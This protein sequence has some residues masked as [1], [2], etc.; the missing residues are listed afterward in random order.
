MERSASL[1]S[2]P[3]SSVTPN[4]LTGPSQLITQR[5]S[6]HA[7]PLS[8]VVTSSPASCAS[9]SAPVA[10]AHRWSPPVVVGGAGRF[11]PVA[12]AHR[13]SPSCRGGA[14]AGAV[15][16]P[17]GRCSSRVSLL[18]WWVVGGAGVICPSGRCSSLVSLLS[19]WCVGGCGHLPQW[20]VLI[21]GLPPVGGGW[22]V[23]LGGHLPQWPVLIAG[24]P[25]VAVVR[26]R[27]RSL[28]P[29]AGAHRGSPPVVMG[30]GRSLAWWPVL[31]GN[32]PSSG[33]AWAAGSACTRSHGDVS[34]RA[35][36]VPIE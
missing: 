18:G 13:W 2:L 5:S 12:G 14:W 36:N 23:V 19:W 26:R 35:G 16:C 31:T 15:I 4:T 24:L 11:A 32:S 10:G 8:V 28:A 17:S 7:P 21:A 20:P 6:S 30:G 3:S 22:W 34:K 9:S 25:P 33:R 29:V 1:P 27:V